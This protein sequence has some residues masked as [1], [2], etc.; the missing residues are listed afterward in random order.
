MSNKKIILVSLIVII[1][2]IPSIN[3]ISIKTNNNKKNEVLQQTGSV[4]GCVSYSHRP[5]YTA[6]PFAIVWIGLK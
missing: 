3:A 6:V 1:M 4:Y 2:L 5:G